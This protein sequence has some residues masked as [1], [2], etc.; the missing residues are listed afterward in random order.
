[1][2]PDYNDKLLIPKENK[3]SCKGILCVI[4]P[5][6]CVCIIFSVCFIHELTYNNELSY[7]YT[8]L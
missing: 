6:T 3:K 8:I 1:M 2:L 5:V 4:V 7:N